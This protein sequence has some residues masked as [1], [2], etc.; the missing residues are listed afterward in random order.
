MQVSAFARTAISRLG[1]FSRLNDVTLV[2]VWDQDTL[3]SFGVV[4]SWFDNTD[5]FIYGFRKHSIPGAG[6]VLQWAL[7]QS[8]ITR[9]KKNLCLGY[10][11]S[12]GSLNSNL[13][14]VQPLQIKGITISYGMHLKIT[15]MEVFVTGQASYWVK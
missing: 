3:I 8:A 1:D 2:E 13:N 6:D 10:S 12:E 4:E 14:G 5:V 15:S 7:I 11:M 9:G